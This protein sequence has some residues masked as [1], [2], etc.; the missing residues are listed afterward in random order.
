CSARSTSAPLLQLR[1]LRLGFPQDGDIGVR[2]FPKREEILIGGA[3]FGLV[4]L[5]AVSARQSEASQRAPGKVHHHSPVVNEFLKF[6]CR[7]APVVEQEIGFPTQI[8]G[9]QEYREV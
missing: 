4:A 5:Q 3:G 6:C 1:V 9:A 7:S 2:V 8:N